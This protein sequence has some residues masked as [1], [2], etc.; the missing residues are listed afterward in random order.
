MLALLFSMSDAVQV[1]LLAGALYTAVGVFRLGWITNFLSHSVICG[2]MTGASVII[3]MSQ[4]CWGWPLVDLMLL[5]RIKQ[6]PGRPR[7]QTLFLM[8]CR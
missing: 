7:R 4:V 5:P 1:C 3:A 8:D 6:K 2:F